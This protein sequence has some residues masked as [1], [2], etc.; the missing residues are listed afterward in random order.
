MREKCRFCKSKNLK[1]FLKRKKE[2]D[3]VECQGCGLVFV[4]PFPTKSEI[5]KIYTKETFAKF[6]P[7]DKTRAGYGHY[8]EEGNIR[9][10]MMRKIVSLVEKYK[11]RGKLLEAGCALGFF[12]EEAKKSGFE[13][14]GVEIMDFA[15]DYCRKRGLKQ[16]SKGSL[17]ENKFPDS[18]FDVVAAL[19]LLEHIWDPGAFLQEA[20]RVLKPNGI[21]VIFVPDRKSI[22]ARLMGKHWF[23]YYHYQHLFV[24]DKKTLR[25]YLDKTGFK[26]LGV[27]SEGPAW[28]FTKT[29]FER[30]RF[31]Y[32]NPILIKL[33]QMTKGILDFLKINR[34][35]IL[36]GN[37]WVVAEKS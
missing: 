15:V 6:N 21:L 18:S 7:K 13:V 8:L 1:L 16:I 33:A 4:S 31:Y 24:F 26:I 29:P 17:E 35:P 25:N 34:V 12:L 37:R 5:R 3:L 9:R 11:K 36:M 32:S 27:G 28:F 20:K 14:W 2:R 22:T 10:E 19:Q 30:V 23:G